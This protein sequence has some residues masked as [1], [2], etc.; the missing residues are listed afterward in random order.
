MNNAISFMVELGSAE[1][2]VMTIA[3]LTTTVTQITP[4]ITS[5]MVAVAM[6]MYIVRT[7]TSEV[8]KW[9]A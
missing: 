6:S 9:L 5:L 4:V 3:S 2:L 8:R 1:S 7:I